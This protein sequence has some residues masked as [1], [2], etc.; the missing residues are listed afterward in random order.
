MVRTKS[1]PV[2][3]NGPHR[4]ERS[5]VRTRGPSLSAVVGFAIPERAMRAMA[6]VMGEP[7]PEDVVHGIG[8]EMEDP[9]TQEYKPGNL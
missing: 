5:P 6:R 4:L 3:W 9:P 2:R 8:Y 7:Y 1:A